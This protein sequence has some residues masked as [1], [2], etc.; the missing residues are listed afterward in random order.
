M[1]NAEFDPQIVPK[2]KELITNIFVKISISTGTIYGLYDTSGGMP[3][4]T[5]GFRSK[6]YNYDSG[7]DLNTPLRYYNLYIEEKEIKGDA[8]K[9][10]KAFYH[11]G[12]NFINTTDPWFRRDNSDRYELTRASDAFCYVQTRGEVNYVSSR[13][14][15]STW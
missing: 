6:G 1:I 3:E 4:Y 8:T 13:F 11:N 10:T 14:V 5:L 2:N 15:I 12:F 7:F 9:E